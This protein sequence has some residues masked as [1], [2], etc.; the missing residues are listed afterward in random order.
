MTTNAVEPIGQIDG[1]PF[2]R[3][4][5]APAHLKSKTTLNAWRLKP[6]PG[7]QPAAYVRARYYKTLV[8][9]YD[10][11]DAVPLPPRRIGDAWAYRDAHTC[12]RCGEIKGYVIDGKQCGD[13]WR[14]DDAKRAAVYNRTCRRC[15]TVKPRRLKHLLC[16]PCLR[17]QRAEK[18]AERARRIERAQWCAG[19]ERYGCTVRHASQREVLRHFRAGNTYFPVRFCAE[20]EQRRQAEMAQ[21]RA[22][23][24]A[25]EQAREAARRTELAELRDWAIEALNDPNVVILDT[26]TTGLHDS[27]RIVDIAVV[28]AAGEPLLN[29]LVNPCEPIPAE[30]SDIHGITDDMVADAPMFTE[31]L[32][33]LE[34]AL[35]GKRILIYNKLFDLARLGHELNVSY[36]E[37]RDPLYGANGWLGGLHAKAEDA[38]EP[39]SAWYG[40]WSDWHGNYRWQ[41]LGGGHRAHGDCLAVID[42]LKAMAR[43]SVYEDEDGN[44]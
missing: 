29:T 21:A 2:F 43:P 15:R 38:M 20:C 23:E 5:T 32:P 12:R 30:A 22:D 18:A 6:A 41:R 27:A 19:R 1:I 9:L 31:I 16:A 35:S 7:Q 13:C 39:Y 14:R 25:R 44:D 11:A 8:G 37:N 36:D 26:E 40:E 24:R 17:E 42:C 10:P 28:T 4:G 34:K 3:N 33:D